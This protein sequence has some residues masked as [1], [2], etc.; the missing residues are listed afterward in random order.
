MQRGRRATALLVIIRNVHFFNE[1]QDIMERHRCKALHQSA[2]SSS[3]FYSFVVTADSATY[4]LS[5]AGY[6]CSF[7]SL[8]SIR[9]IICFIPFISFSLPYKNNSPPFSVGK[10]FTTK[11]LMLIYIHFLHHNVSR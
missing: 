4:L 7:S 1:A 3:S 11:H 2:T 9:F 10:T 8:V 6:C 5:S